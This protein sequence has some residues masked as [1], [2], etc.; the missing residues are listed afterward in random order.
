MQP[1][2][3]T[4]SG[5]P[6]PTAIVVDGPEEKTGMSSASALLPGS[7]EGRMRAKPGA[8]NKAGWFARKLHDGLSA[9]RTPTWIGAHWKQRAAVVRWEAKASVTIG[10]PCGL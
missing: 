9:L 8:T 6:Q 10:M 4:C 2:A 5:K 1:D 3:S 7:W